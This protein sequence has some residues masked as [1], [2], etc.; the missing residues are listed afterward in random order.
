MV[1]AVQLVLGVNLARSQPP[2]APVVGDAAAVGDTGAAPA[3]HGWM[4]IRDD[5][6]QSTILLHLPPRTA[7]GDEPGSVRIAPGV[8]GL[9]DAVGFHGDRVWLALTPERGPANA[10]LRRIVTVTAE[11]SLGGSWVY[12]PGR[13]EVLAPLPGRDE[14]AGFVGTA[15]GPVAMTRARLDLAATNATAEWSLHVLIGTR[16]FGMTMPWS[17][18]EDAPQPGSTVRLAS[19]GETLDL[20]VFPAKPGEWVHYRALLPPAP[21]EADATHLQLGWSR[22]VHPLAGLSRLEGG[23][24]GTAFAPDSVWFVGDGRGRQLVAASWLA[25]GTLELVALRAS[26]ASLLANVEGVPR[27]HRISPLNSTGSIAV[28]WWEANA[29]GTSGRE[30]VAGST[31]SRKFTIAEVSTISGKELYRGEHKGGGLVTGSEFKLLAVA[32]LLVT[33]LIL[34][35]ALRADPTAQLVLPAGFAA[36]D[37]LRRIIAACADLVPGVVIAAFSMGLEPEAMLSPTIFIGPRAEP[38]AWLLAIGLTI[39]HCTVGEAMTGRTIG[40]ALAGCEVASLLRD[41]ASG[42]VQLG[43]VMVWQ[44]LVRNVIRWGI[45]VLGILLL[46]DGGRRHPADA[47][48]RTVVVIRTEEPEDE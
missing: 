4:I 27:E 38:M 45:P 9:T 33:T 42:E 22:E 39:F 40:K 24:G 6:D 29:P 36:A 28:L 34:L 12:P 14:I 7:G 47:A 30:P 23:A 25:G 17:G 11:R 10:M 32:L 20:L 31:A 15:R 46:I 8:A 3:G 26:G 18:A 43:P 19:T 37:P 5:R 2:V 48:A 16:W 41:P 35:F 21:A 44:A 1:L 13:L